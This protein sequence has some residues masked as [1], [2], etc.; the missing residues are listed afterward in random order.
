MSRIKSGNLK[1]LKVV[2]KAD[3]NGSVEALKA[4]LLKL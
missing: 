1:Q 2:V 3:S 4:A